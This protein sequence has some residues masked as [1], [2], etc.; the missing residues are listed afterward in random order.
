M[1]TKDFVEGLNL[2]RPHYDNQDGYNLSAE[3]D[4]IYVYATDRPLPPESVKRLFDLNWFQPDVENEDN[5]IA[6]Y[7]FKEGWAVFV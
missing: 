4:I 3:H 1:M 5:D 2:I 6:K 7:D